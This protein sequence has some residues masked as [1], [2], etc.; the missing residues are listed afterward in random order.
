MLSGIIPETTYL[1]LRDIPEK[2]LM[3]NEWVSI[4][5]EK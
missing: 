4:R 1:K 2:D 3:A 5:K